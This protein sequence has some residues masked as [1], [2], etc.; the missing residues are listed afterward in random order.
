MNWKDL[1][2]TDKLLHAAVSFILVALLGLFCT[3]FLAL[4][5]GIVIGIC[6]ELYDDLSDRGTPEVLDLVADAIGVSLG[7]LY[8]LIL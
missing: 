6:K 7:A 1:L 2:Q 5:I 4:C 8:L 3:P